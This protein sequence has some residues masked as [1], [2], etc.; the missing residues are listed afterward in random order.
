MLPEIDCPE[1]A[2]LA[3]YAPSVNAARKQSAVLPKSAN[4]TWYSE[5][6]VPC[7]TLAR[8]FLRSTHNRTLD[9]ACYVHYNDQDIPLKRAVRA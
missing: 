5:L 4:L 9:T 2:A 6:F 8:P 3:W 1:W 7:E